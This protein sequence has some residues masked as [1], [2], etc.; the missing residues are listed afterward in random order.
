[1]SFFIKKKICVT[2]NGTFHVDD[3]FATATLSILNNGNIKIVRTRDPEMF[4]K[5]DY[6]YDVGGEND[7]DKN[8]FDHHQKGGGGKRENGIPYSSFGLIWKK[9]G[10]QICGSKEVADYIDTKIVAPIDATDE[11]FDIY[12]PKVKEI[13]PY[14]VEAI[15]L[16]VIPTWREEN[17]NLDKI[18]KK[19]VDKVV[20]LLKREIK[21]AK[22]DI[23]GANILLED[24]KNAEDKRIIVSSV[25]FPR[26]LLQNTL[27][28]LPEPIYLVYP[29]SRNNSWKVEAIKKSPETMESRK[30]FPESWRG[31]TNGDE[32]LKEVTGISDII[33]CHQNGFYLNTGLKESAIK[34]A[35]KSLIA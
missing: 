5:G 32:R 34:L 29:S 3:L 21:I 13:F 4:K 24:Y 17:R 31:F 20:E 26:Y 6:V 22:D 28:K 19:Q 25:D 15:F 23:E 7:G 8:K 33:F 10:E 30:L 12:V 14:S 11:G 9:Y 35:E 18:F 27:S 2:H 1:M 16:S